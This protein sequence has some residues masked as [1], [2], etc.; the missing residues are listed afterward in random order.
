VQASAQSRVARRGAMMAGRA[1]ADEV[2]VRSPSILRDETHVG[3][4]APAEQMC[5]NALWA[6]PK[7]RHP[8]C[9]T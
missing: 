3:T 9:T 8:P 7:L 6:V 2:S 4:F 1:Q 5:P